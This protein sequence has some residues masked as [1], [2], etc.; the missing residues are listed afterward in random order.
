[1]CVNARNTFACAQTDLHTMIGI[2][3]RRYLVIASMLSSLAYR[4]FSCFFLYQF[5]FAFIFFCCHRWRCDFCC[6]CCCCR[7]IVHEYTRFCEWWWWTK[8]TSSIH[9]C[10][11][12]FKMYLASNRLKWLYVD[13]STH[14]LHTQKNIMV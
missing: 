10:L 13:Y 3:I 5:F 12:P 9:L 7:R 14:C 6:C 1:M 8:V 4:Q 2:L 11:L